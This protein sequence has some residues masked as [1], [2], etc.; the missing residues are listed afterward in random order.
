MTAVAGVVLSGL[1]C[2][3]S[4][5]V[6]GEALAS[7]RGEAAV[8]GWALRGFEVSPYFDEQVVSYVFDP[9]VLIHI[10]APAAARLDPGKPVL[11][12]LYAL[13]NGN[14]TAQTIGKRLHE[15]DDWHYAIQHIGAQTR[16]LREAMEDVTVVVAYLEARGRSWPTWRRTHEESGAKLVAAVESIKSRLREA[17]PDAAIRVCLNGHS[18]GGSMIFGYL[19]ECGGV[20][21]DVER[22]CFLDSNYGYSDDERHG[23]MLIE[24]LRR[25]GRR[26][27]VVLAYDDRE[28]TLD[29]KK[30]V[31]PTGGTYRATHRMLDR[32]KGEVELT[33]TRDGDF[34]CQRGMDGRIDIRVHGN[35]ANKILHTALVGDMNGFIHSLTVG[36]PLEDKVAPFGGPVA[37]ERWIQDEGPTTQAN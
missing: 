37:Y 3:G 31:G 20:P 15:G 24:W 1:G 14:T 32:F 7:Q 4:G 12:V 34:T 36:T 26:Q 2:S 27:L 30:V 18:G 10:N 25:G 28:I 33:E 11:L 17:I 16:C 8:A 35:P 13:P 6:R 23:D 19:N 21:G 22:V 5:G 9:D 29:G